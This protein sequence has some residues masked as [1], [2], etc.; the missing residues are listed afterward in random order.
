MAAAEL[1]LL[2]A[3][4]ISHQV[5][6]HPLRSMAGVVVAHLWVRAVMAGQALLFWTRLITVALARRGELAL[7]VGVAVAGY[8]VET[9]V[10]AD[11]A[12][13]VKLQFIG[14]SPAA[15]EWCNL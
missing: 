7:V 15:N 5:A 8:I 12:G 2:V 9:A 13:A 14:Y 6:L 3:T 10:L 11:Q 1:R 4:L